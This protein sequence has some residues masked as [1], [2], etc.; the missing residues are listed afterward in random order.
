[1]KLYVI[2]FGAQWLWIDIMTKIHKTA[3]ISKYAIIGENVT[4][5]AYSVISNVYR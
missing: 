1:M 3:V 2:L 5:G 4:V